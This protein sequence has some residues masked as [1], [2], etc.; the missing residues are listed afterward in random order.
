VDHKKPRS[1][2]PELA[3]SIENLLLPCRRCNSSKGGKL[4]SEDEFAELLLARSKEIS[5]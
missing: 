4:L 1:K 3:M 5:A 2:F